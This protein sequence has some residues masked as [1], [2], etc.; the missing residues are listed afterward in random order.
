MIVALSP[1]PLGRPRLHLRETVSTNERAKELAV[2]G[3]PHGTLV[4][5]RA[6]TAGRGRHGRTWSAPAGASV[7]ASLVVRIPG[8]SA[9]MLPLTAAVAVCEACERCAPV[10]CAIKWP[11][12]VWIDGRKVAGI[13]LEGRPQEGWAVVGIGINVAVRPGELPGEL[14]ETATSLAEDGDGDGAPGVE[15]VLTATT[16]AL[17][18]W[19]TASPQKLAAAWGARDALRGRPIR[20]DGGRGIA[21]GIDPSGALLVW[22]DGRRVE[23]YAGEVALVRPGDGERAGSR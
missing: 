10:E 14:R 17:E 23:L 13:L 16:A 11:N 20:W 2:A 9:A 5:A 22:C 15:A 8:E 12:D 7:L 6:Q 1:A 18:R 19:L 4:S 21:E 3:A